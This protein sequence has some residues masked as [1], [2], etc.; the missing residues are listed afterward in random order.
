[1]RIFI[2]WALLDSCD[3]GNSN[4]PSRDTTRLGRWATPTRRAKAAMESVFSLLQKNVLDR[5]KRATRN[6]LR[7]AIITWIE[8]TYHRRRR[9][10]RLGK[11][12][13]SEYESIMTLTAA[14][15]A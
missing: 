10:T 4:V 7:A 14:L 12:T 11:S 1:M 5:Q 9:Q 8:R 6:E 2:G 3:H 13:P 15:A